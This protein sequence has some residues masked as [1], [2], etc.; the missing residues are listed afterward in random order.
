MT[1]KK[2]RK[3]LTVWVSSTGY[4]LQ[5]YKSVF[6]NQFFSLLCIETISDV[7]PYQTTCWKNTQ[8][9]CWTSRACR[10]HKLDAKWQSLCGN[11]FSLFVVWKHLPNLTT[12]EWIDQ[13][14]F[15]K[16]KMGYIS[17]PSDL[18]VIIGITSYYCVILK[19]V[20]LL[21]AIKPIQNSF[22]PELLKITV[23]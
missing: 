20:I 7:C 22:F 11:G 17:L 3:I 21:D 14:L 2:R 8:Y 6:F 10:L 23:I 19:M 12:L 4:L 16:T 9:R 13:Q 1:W 15:A 5:L 18:N